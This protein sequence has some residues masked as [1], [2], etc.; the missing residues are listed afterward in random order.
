MDRCF[1]FSVLSVPYLYYIFLCGNHL[2]QLSMAANLNWWLIVS[3]FLVE[4]T[5]CDY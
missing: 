4:K 3:S 1:G 2:G 5:L